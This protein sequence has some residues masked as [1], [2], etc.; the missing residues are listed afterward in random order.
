M[1]VGT[2]LYILQLSQGVL[3]S[4]PGPG[5]S[6]RMDSQMKLNKKD[7]KWKKNKTQIVD[8]H[9]Q[10]VAWFVPIVKINSTVCIEDLH[11]LAG[12][13]TVKALQL[14]MHC[15]KLKVL[16]CFFKFKEK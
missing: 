2:V 1:L 9:K 8:I 10:K 4:L 14:R 16:S 12:V 5:F 3:T 7:W 15:C 6:A 11:I 13:V